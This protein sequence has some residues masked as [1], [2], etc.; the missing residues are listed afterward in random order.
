MTI[1][2]LVQSIK[3]VY[4]E[5]WNWQLNDNPEYASQCGQNQFDHL[6]QHISPESF[7]DRKIH[8]QKM[9]SRSKFLLDELNR[10]LSSPDTEMVEV[11]S[12]SKAKIS[13]EVFVETLCDE[14]KAYE[15]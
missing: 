10:H 4:E 13:L 6:L 11:R 7:V 3:E 12:L 15:M 1:V 8:S 5:D 2:E 9:L 14:I